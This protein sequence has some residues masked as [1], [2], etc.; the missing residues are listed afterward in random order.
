MKHKR[1]E[2]QVKRNTLAF[3]IRE[4]R[5]K[6][7]KWKEKAKKAAL[8]QH[9][10]MKELSESIRHSLWLHRVHKV[11]PEARKAHIAA[12]FLKG[13]P[14]AAVELK[15]YQRNFIGWTPEHYWRQIAEMVYRFSEPTK[16]SETYTSRQHKE[17]LYKQ[18]IAWR[19][20]HPAYTLSK[21]KSIRG[22]ESARFIKMYG[23]AWFCYE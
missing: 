11:R 22:E 4:V 2:L 10:V 15:A 8:K 9:T 16:Y 21:D 14:Y 6:E 18:L 17:D 12:A 7:L 13:M 5:N 23:D 3:E 1:T 19:N 20:S